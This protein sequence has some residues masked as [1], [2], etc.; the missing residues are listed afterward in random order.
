MNRITV[1]SY[2]VLALL[3][4]WA[5]SLPV[6]ICVETPTK[7]G[8][9]SKSKADD[10]SKESFVIEN[11]SDKFQFENDGTYVRTTAMKI[12]IQAE[13]GV[14]QFSVAKFGYQ[15]SSES[16]AVDYVRVTQ[17]DGTVVESPSDTFQDMPADV[18]RLAPFYTDAHEVHVAV[19]G[20]GVGD[21]LEYEAHWQHT[22]PLIPGQF[23]LDYNF[24]HQ[25]IVLQEVVEVRVPRE[26]AVK[27]KSATIAP[28]TAE[29]AQYITYSWTNSHLQNPD[30][31]Q[32]KQDAQKQTWQQIRGR[33]PQSD[34][35]L[36]SFKSWQ[37]LGNWYEEL[38]RDRAKP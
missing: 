20:L 2:F 21:L 14:Q 4:A 11:S 34:I 16:F 38:Q 3:V 17:K 32:Q 23:W 6:A 33:L 24:A 5:W 9:S 18:T 30:D 25:G 22:K 31:N 27:L 7:T 1:R 28:V 8:E 37:E 15:K 19:K 29:S 35:E 26:R 36:S 10:Y 13:A 12:R